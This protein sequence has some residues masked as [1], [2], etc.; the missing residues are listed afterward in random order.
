MLAGMVPVDHLLA[1]LTLS[2][3]LIAVPGPSVLFTVSRALAVGRRDAL[4]TVLGNAT[5]VYVQVVAIA[6]GLGAV[7]ARS[8]Q[9]YTILKLVGAAYLI[10]LGVQAIRHRR[11]LATAF[12]AGAAPARTRRVLL[13][14]FVVGIANPKSIVFFAA[15]L[16]QFTDRAAGHVPVQIL[17][18]GALF[19]CI[20]L[21]S[22]SAW[23]LLAA[24]ARSWFA[25]SPRRLTLVG[26]TSGLIMIGL[27]TSLAMTGRK[28]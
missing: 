10:H 16:P 22:D 23:A 3:V 24:T 25:R 4:L 12:D 13:D 18:L 9:A 28:D 2:F 5:G 6:F 26:G 15:V 14:G 21:L 11:S 27:G 20:G 8:A 19:I 7:I 17:V 1:F